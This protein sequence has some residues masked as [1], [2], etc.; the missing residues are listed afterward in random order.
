VLDC[1]RRVLLREH[2][3]DGIATVEPGDVT[4]IMRAA[5][6]WTYVSLRSSPAVMDLA[7]AG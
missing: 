2:G 7:F 6:G 3:S 5:P 4:T 1:V